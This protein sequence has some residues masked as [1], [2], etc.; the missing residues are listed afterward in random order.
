[1]ECAS[2]CLKMFRCKAFYFSQDGNICQLAIMTPL[3]RSK[4]SLPLSTDSLM[5]KIYISPIPYTGTSN[6]LIRVFFLQL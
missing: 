1:M 2:E 3:D 5:L 6:N 4:L